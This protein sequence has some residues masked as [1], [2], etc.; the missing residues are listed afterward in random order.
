MKLYEDRLQ[1]R[2]FNLTSTPLV[3]GLNAI[4]MR[5]NGLETKELCPV[6]IF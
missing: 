3:F 2:R 5:L 1:F 6:L 4:M